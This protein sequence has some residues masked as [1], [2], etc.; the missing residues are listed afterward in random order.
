MSIRSYK[1]IYQ[2]FEDLFPELA[3]RKSGWKGVHFRDRYILIEMK[4]D[5]N[6]H[7]FYFSDDNWDM[8]CKPA[9][10]KMVKKE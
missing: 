5:T 1:Q 7:F 10:W 6:I 2:K 4:D 9:D 3:S 8:Y